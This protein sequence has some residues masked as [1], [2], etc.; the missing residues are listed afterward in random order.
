MPDLKLF[1]VDENTGRLRLGLPSPPETVEGIDLLVQLVAFLFLN[2]GGRSIFQPGRSGGLRRYIGL[3]FDPED[4]S[5]LFADFRLMT[6][7]IEQIIKEEQVVIRR[8][9][10]E[11]LLSLQLID[12]V[13]DEDQAEIEIIVQVVNEEQQQQQA[14][15]AV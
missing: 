2:N 9:A 1:I 8:P 4:P 5:E 14:I 10:S 3:N 7:R 12:I 11:R 6:T 15:V 13:P